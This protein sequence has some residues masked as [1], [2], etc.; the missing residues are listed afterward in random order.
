MLLYLNDDDDIADVFNLIYIQDS[1][2]FIK[3]VKRDYISSLHVWGFT[4]YSFNYIKTLFK[5]MQV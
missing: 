5:L 2:V 1:K 3:C 4:K